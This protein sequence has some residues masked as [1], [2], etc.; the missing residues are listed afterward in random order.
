MLGTLLDFTDVSWASMAR[1]GITLSDTEREAN[2]HTWSFIGEL[3]GVEACRDG[4]LSLGDVDQIS[5]G[6]NR[7]LGPSEA[8]QRLM[9]ALLGEMEEFMPLGWRKLPRSV[10]RWLFQ[11]APGAVSGVPDMLRVPPAAWWSGPLAGLAAGRQRRFP[12]ARAAGAGRARPAAQA[13][14]GMC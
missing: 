10:V 7:L 12:A 5:T 6:M 11:D 4:P 3:M 13:R 2:L 8:G 9:A 1:M 14:P